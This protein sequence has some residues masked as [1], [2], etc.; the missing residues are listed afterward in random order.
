MAGALLKAFE[1][2]EVHERLARR[3]KQGGK[4][5]TKG[6]VIEP[7]ITEGMTAMGREKSSDFTASHRLSRGG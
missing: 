5:M 2:T 6:I 3:A 1:T 7:L 4:T